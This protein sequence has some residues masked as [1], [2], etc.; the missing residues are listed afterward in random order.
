MFQVL[1]VVEA[2]IEVCGVAT[3]VIV[4]GSFFLRFGTAI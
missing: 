4:N 3:V 1:V 2:E